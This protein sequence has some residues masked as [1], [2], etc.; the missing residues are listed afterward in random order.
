MAAP[1]HYQRVTRM[2]EINTLSLTILIGLFVIAGVF[3]LLCGVKLT[4]KADQYA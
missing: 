1:S 2:I 3:V 4:Y